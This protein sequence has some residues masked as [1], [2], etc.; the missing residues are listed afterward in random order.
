M[1][2][3]ISRISNL[4]KSVGLLILVFSLNACVFQQKIDTSL[5]NHWGFSGK[6]SIKAKQKTQNANI[7]WAQQGNNYTITLFG[8]LGQGKVV[9]EKNGNNLTLAHDNQIKRASSPEELLR[10][11]T[12]WSLPISAMNYWL[13]NKPSPKTEAY[14]TTNTSGRI[15]KIEQQNWTIDFV[16][17]YDD[18]RP[19]KITLQRTDI[20]VTIIIKEWQ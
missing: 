6:F 3:L 13:Q 9:I 18:N 17:F 19:K 4:S 8:P 10:K 7:I 20:A 16:S 2:T 5:E 1:Q 11:T 12:G 15:T 14:V